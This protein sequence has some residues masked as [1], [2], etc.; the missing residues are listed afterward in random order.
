M[1][2]NTVIIKLEIDGKERTFTAEPKFRMIRRPAEIGQKSSDAFGPED[3][4]EQVGF[5]TEVFD[6]QFTIDDYYDGI[7]A[8]DGLREFFRII[9]ELN[10][11]TKKTLEETTKNE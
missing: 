11:N 1:S 7:S 2:K 5:L 10:G 8:Q 6:H 9:G 3:L 4:D